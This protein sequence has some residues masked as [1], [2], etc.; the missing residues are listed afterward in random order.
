MGM[1]SS[2]RLVLVAPALAAVLWPMSAAALDQS[3]HRAISR[4][5]CANAGMPWEFCERVGTE[6]YNV[7]HYE[8]NDMSAHAQV[9]LAQG[10]TSCEAANLAAGRVNNL[11]EDVRRDLAAFAK[12]DKKVDA[13]VIATALG[14]ALHT[15]QDNCA[16]RG[17]SNPHHAWLSLSDSC[18]GTKSSPDARPEA[19][20]CAQQETEAVIDAFVVAVDD[21][22]I[23]PDDLDDG[24]DEGW[25]HWPTR[26]EVCEF[27]KSAN[28]WDGN[29]VHWNSG[30]V[31]ASLRDQFTAGIEG[32]T[33]GSDICAGNP[34][35]LNDKP[36]P[37]VDTSQGK[38]L[39]FKLNLF[40][41]GK[42]DS[43]D[44]APPWVDEAE[45]AADNEGTPPEQACAVDPD[46]GDTAFGS[47][48]AVVV[49]AWRRRRR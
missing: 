37:K 44:E 21:A 47:L 1:R 29:D 20:T 10:Q 24:V 43:P 33:V 6:S 45:A 26:T 15:V 8:W 23:D 16:H 13:T 36:G 22:G 18:E 38:S 17:V 48:A 46:G 2:V 42:D 19:I 35:A 34:A 27:L 32:K 7:D 9:D 11:A 5:T 49:L 25:G 14:R 3:K 31:V 12:G 4:D 30:I 39:C 40:C 28:E 41:V